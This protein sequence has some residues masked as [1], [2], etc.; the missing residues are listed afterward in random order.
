MYVPK[1]YSWSFNIYI[2]LGNNLNAAFPNVKAFVRWFLY[3]RAIPSGSRPPSLTREQQREQ[4]E[5]VH[6]TTTILWRLT[7]A[8]PPI[9]ASSM[10]T[11]LIFSLQVAGLCGIVVALVTPA[12]LQRKAAVKPHTFI[13]YIHIEAVTLHTL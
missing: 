13:Y 12:L 6:R 5:Q 3:E 7:A 9:I 1:Y 10:V 8:V 2:L 11:D 4:L